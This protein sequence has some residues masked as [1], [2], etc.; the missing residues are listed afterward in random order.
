MRHDRTVRP[1]K[2]RPSYRSAAVLVTT[3][4]LLAD[5]LVRAASAVVDDVPGGDGLGGVAVRA[6][7][8]HEDGLAVVA[9]L[10]DRLADVGERAVAAGFLAGR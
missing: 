8:R 2:R 6:G 10:G 5:G 7:L 3:R 9:Q 1:R 4:H